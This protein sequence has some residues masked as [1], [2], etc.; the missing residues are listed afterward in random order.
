MRSFAPQC[1]FP[2]EP[3]LVKTPNVRSTFEIIWSCFAVIIIAT[4]SGQHLNVPVHVRPQT[5]W[6]SIR[7]A[8]YLLRRKLRWMLITF[9]AP[10]VRLALAA[11]NLITAVRN[12]RVLAKLALDDGVPWSMVHTS[13]ADMGGIALRFPPVEGGDGEEAAAGF[14]E[15]T[16]SDDWADSRINSILDRWRARHL[17]RRKYGDLPWKPHAPH[18]SLVKQALRDLDKRGYDVLGDKRAASGLLAFQGDTWVVDA[19]QL[20]VAREHGLIDRLPVLYPDAIADK[21]KSDGLL[22]VLAVLQAAWLAVQLIVRKASK[23]PSTP[24]E[25]SSVAF[26]GCAVVLYLAEWFR[27]KDVATTFYFD[28]SPGTASKLTLSAFKNI[29][30]AGPAPEW[31]MR[32]TEVP[33]QALHTPPPSNSLGRSSVTRHDLVHAC[34]LGISSALYGSVHAAGWNLQFPTDVEQLL[35]RIAVITVLA[36]SVGIVAL[37]LVVGNVLYDNV[38][39]FN[40]RRFGKVTVFFLGPLPIWILSFLYIIAR[41]FLLVES[42]RSLYYLPPEAF[43]LTWSASVPHFG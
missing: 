14:N 36:T 25:I 24:L 7:F 8:L 15:A 30:L 20:A 42:F 11:T 23:L 13:V 4:W 9:V 12:N 40:N 17:A 28:V 22:K 35:W 6:Q 34:F 31:A 43:A 18:A 26:T 38:Y 3:A 39:P 16:V 37:G 29:T 21:A 27:P 2:S 5:T 10:E 19:R 1:T 33:N 32:M 41:L